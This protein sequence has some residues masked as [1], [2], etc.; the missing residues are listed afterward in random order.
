[1]D[2]ISF[3]E[4]NYSLYTPRQIK[5]EHSSSNIL[6]IKRSFILRLTELARKWLLDPLHIYSIGVWGQR[7]DRRSD[8]TSLS[9]THVVKSYCKMPDSKN[10]RKKKIVGYRVI[11]I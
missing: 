10:E 1:V 11:H 5:I 9:D 2:S 4:T 7:E 6:Q 3:G 8:S